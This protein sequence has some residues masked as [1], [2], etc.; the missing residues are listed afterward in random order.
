MTLITMNV[1]Y[2]TQSGTQD[3][4]FVKL[5]AHGLQQILFSKLIFVF[6]WL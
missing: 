6:H 5:V 1:H 3:R 2:L 4:K